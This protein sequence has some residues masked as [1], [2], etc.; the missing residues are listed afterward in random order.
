MAKLDD[1][2]GIPRYIQA[3]RIIE[4]EIRSGVWKPGSAIPS[5]VR[6]SQEYGIAKTTAGKAHA[7]LAERGLV[8]A[9][10]GVGMVVLPRARWA[11]PEG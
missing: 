2:S 11:E 10:P 5:Q 4:S 1:A 8:T 9:V 6:I 3:A 7:R